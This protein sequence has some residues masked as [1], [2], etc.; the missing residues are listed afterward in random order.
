MQP[1][2]IE[3]SIHPSILPSARPPADRPTSLA[4]YY[5]HSSPL[6]PGLAQI[7]S[8]CSYVCMC[9]R[10]C[11]CGVCGMCVCVCVYICV[12]VCVCMRVWCVWVSGWV[13]F[14]CCAWL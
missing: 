11:M 4:E 10:V 7:L 14:T 2:M 3:P 5:A 8:V 13:F 9:T 6:S 1:I 12:Y